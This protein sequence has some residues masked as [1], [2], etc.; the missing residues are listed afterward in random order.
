MKIF[1]IILVLIILMGCNDDNVYIPFYQDAIYI[2]DADGSNKQKVIDVDG[3]SNVQFL[4]NSDKLLYMLNRT[5]GTN[6]GS[7]YTVNTNGSE[8]TQISGELK[9]KRDLPSI[10]DDGSKIIFWAFDDSRDYTYDL[11]MV[12]PMGIEITNLTQTEDVSEKEA[13]FINYQ[14]LEYL[15]Y[16]TYFNENEIN[17]STI[18]MMNTTTFE[19]DTL[20]VEEIEEEWG[21]KHPLYY[22]NYEIL[23]VVSGQVGTTASSYLYSYDSLINGNPTL[24]PTEVYGYKMEISLDFHK[25]IFQSHDITIYDIIQNEVN[26]LV[27]GY[28]FD[29]FNDKVI[30]SSGRHLADSDIYSIK[31]DGSNNK[32]LTEDGIY[33]RFSDDGSQIVFIG[34]YVTNPRRNLITN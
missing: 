12:D 13:T 6:T 32:M 28:W 23:F 25:L 16:V 31:F 3:C 11:H 30:Y 33:P 21:F 20:Y 18:S 8:I 15:L 7:L 5:D 14:N 34:K 24:I 10:S 1:I 17:Y 29:P 9:I 27:D 22:P 4:P 2:M 26:F 19:I